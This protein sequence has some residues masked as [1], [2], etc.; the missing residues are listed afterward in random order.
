MAK[1]KSVI[2]QKLRVPVDQQTLYFQEE[3]MHND[4]VLSGISG[5]G[6]GAMVYLS[7]RHFSLTIYSWL[8]GSLKEVQ[9]KLSYNI[10]V[11]VWIKGVSRVILTLC[12]ESSQWGAG[13]G[14]TPGQ[15]LKI[16]SIIRFIIV[17]G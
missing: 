6:H 12:T 9:L 15:T 14:Q 16:K 10:M 3:M 11:I 8:S 5:L 1:L 4:S 13:H 7:K 17:S 2:K